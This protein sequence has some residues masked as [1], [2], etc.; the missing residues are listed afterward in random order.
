MMENI[1]DK[2]QK[3]KTYVPGE[4]YTTKYN[5]KQQQKKSLQDKHR[6]AYTLFNE[7]TF[8]LTSDEMEHVLYLIDHNPNFKKL[9]KRASNETIILAFIFYTKIAEN[10]D[11]KLSKYSITKKYQLTN[12]TFEIILCR[13]LYEELQRMYI[14]P[15]EPKETN[16]EILN[17]GE[18]R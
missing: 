3:Y 14:I 7:V 15:V 17:K 18:I 11:I 4:N 9:H 16:H 5:R 10:T 6:I 12:T 13:L 2:I 8:H 1:Q